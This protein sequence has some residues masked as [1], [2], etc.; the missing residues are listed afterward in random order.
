MCA[1]ATL[2][3]ANDIEL[4]VECDIERRVERFLFLWLCG[5]LFVCMQWRDVVTDEQF[6]CDQN[7]LG[8]DHQWL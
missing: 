2:Y 6:M 5:K 4:F 1:G 3:G 8:A 7:L